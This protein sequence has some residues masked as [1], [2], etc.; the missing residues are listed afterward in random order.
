MIPKTSRIEVEMNEKWM[1]ENPELVVKSFLN[2]FEKAKENELT[3]ISLD[4]S[5][6]GY[7]TL[8]A[9]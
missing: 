6:K 8:I 2:F 7:K 1:D 5:Y 3:K 9:E 4:S